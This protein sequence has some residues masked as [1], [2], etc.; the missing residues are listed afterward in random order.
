MIHRPS[1]RQKCHDPAQH[2]CSSWSL[3]FPVA[4]CAGERGIGAPGVP[5]WGVA[6]G[7]ECPSSSSSSQV[8]SDHCLRAA[9][10][11]IPW[12]CSVSSGSS[13]LSDGRDFEALNYCYL[14][15]QILKSCSLIKRSPWKDTGKLPPRGNLSYFPFLCFPAPPSLSVSLGRA[16]VFQAVLFVCWETVSL[17]IPCPLTPHCAAASLPCAWWRFN[18]YTG[19]NPFPILHAC[20]GL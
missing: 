1:Q 12:T 8:N 19:T 15:L 13:P 17:H 16:C 9:A 7:E 2:P 6:V 3:L 14:I 10:G 18:V 20:L 5:C 4:L 11:S